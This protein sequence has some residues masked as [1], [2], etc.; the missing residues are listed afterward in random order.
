MIEGVVGTPGG[1]VLAVIAMVSAVIAA[2]FYLRLVL[3]MVSAPVPAGGFAA[4]LAGVEDVGDPIYEPVLAA[5]SESH[6]VSDRTGGAAGSA[7]VSTLEAAS[8]A[9]ADVASEAADQGVIPV[10]LSI[11]TAIAV[12]GGFTVLFGLWPSPII[13][14]AHAATLLL[15]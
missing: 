15:H 13:N 1:D 4:G 14:F 11:A 5:S 2:F 12:C 10:P 9:V 6:A 8:G 7:A 3:Y